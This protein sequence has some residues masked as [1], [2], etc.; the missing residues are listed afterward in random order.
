MPRSRNRPHYRVLSMGLQ[1]SLASSPRQIGPLVGI[2]EIRVL[3]RMRWHCATQ[4][5]VDEFL[6]RIRKNGG[7]SFIIS[8]FCLK[9]EIFYA[10]LQVI[11]KHGVTTHAQHNL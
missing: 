11:L 5:K 9:T 1:P 3:F 4:G 10:L 2:L 7:Y 6:A 8:S